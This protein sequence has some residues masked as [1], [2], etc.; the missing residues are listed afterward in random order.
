L[1]EHIASIFRVEEE[2]NKKLVRSRW[3]AEPDPA[4]FLL[5]LLFNTGDVGATFFLNVGML[6]N[7]TALQSERPYS[8]VT[9]ARTSN[10]K[11]LYLFITLIQL[12]T[13]ILF[14]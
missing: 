6:P 8:R 10:R 13:S 2:A 11:M 9:S 3:Q 12:E 1:E 14:R 5:G 7:C 4:S